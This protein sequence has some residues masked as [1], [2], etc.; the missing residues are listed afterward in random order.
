[1]DRRKAQSKGEDG[2]GKF[3][4]LQVVTNATLH[5]QHIAMT[6]PLLNTRLKWLGGKGAK[7]NRR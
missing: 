6:P 7:G 1:M 4:V 5:R 3:A 2:L